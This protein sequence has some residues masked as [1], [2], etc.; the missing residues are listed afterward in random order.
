MAKMRNIFPAFM[1]FSYFYRLSVS[2]GLILSARFLALSSPAIVSALRP[3]TLTAR[4]TLFPLA[5][6]L[7]RWRKIAQFI[8]VEPGR[9]DGL[10]QGRAAPQACLA[11]SLMDGSCFV[12]RERVR[13]ILGEDSLDLLNL[14]SRKRRYSPVCVFTTRRLSVAHPGRLHLLCGKYGRRNNSIHSQKRQQQAGEQPVKY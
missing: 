13:V 7:R 9:F 14:F 4:L 8:G 6:V 1:V 2:V 11:E 10:V 5:A 12:S 3:I